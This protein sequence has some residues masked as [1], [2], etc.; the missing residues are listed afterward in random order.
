[1]DKRSRRDGSLSGTA[2]VAS[3]EPAMGGEIVSDV[4]PGPRPAAPRS[5]Q[6]LRRGQGK[7]PA[8]S[9]SLSARMRC[10]AGSSFAQRA[11]HQTEPA[12]GTYGVCSD[13]LQKSGGFEM[14]VSEEAPRRNQPKLLPVVI[15]GQNVANQPDVVKQPGNCD[16]H[17][18]SEASASQEAER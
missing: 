8:S 4:A 12:F 6:Y 16:R 13:V 2:S 3:K 9:M 18:K 11:S 17:I 1:M 15:C 7:G 10:F 14:P 5:W